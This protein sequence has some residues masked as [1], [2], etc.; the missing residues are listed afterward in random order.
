MAVNLKQTNNEEDEL[1]KPAAEKE[2]KSSGPAHQGSKDDY[3]L[4]ELKKNSD[5]I[6]R[7]TKKI[8]N[9]V[10]W[11][12]IFAVVKLLIILTPLV[13]AIIYVPRLL[14]DPGALLKNSWLDAYIDNI[15]DSAADKIDPDRI[16]TSDIDLDR[17]PPE[18][19]RLLQ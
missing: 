15:V 4:E 5:E 2:E 8:H 19:R 16:D 14:D 10:I 18:V 7:L 12:R 13:L 9:F 11:T 3:I 17:L 1:D 6:L